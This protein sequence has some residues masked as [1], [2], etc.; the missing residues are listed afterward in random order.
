MNRDEHAISAH[1]KRRPYSHGKDPAT[2][3]GTAGGA[4]DRRGARPLDEGDDLQSLVVQSIEGIRRGARL[5]GTAADEVQ[6]GMSNHAGR[7]RE[8]LV[9][10]YRAG[11]GDN[12]EI[13]TA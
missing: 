1:N 8:L 13:T 3:D 2:A 4:G 7:R 12:R 6:P 9:A 5:E 10:F 11:A